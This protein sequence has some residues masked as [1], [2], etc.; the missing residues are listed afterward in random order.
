MPSTKRH[1]QIA[2][3]AE[4]MS[5]SIA[6]GPDTKYEEVTRYSRYQKFRDIVD[7]PPALYLNVSL[8]QARIKVFEQI[9]DHCQ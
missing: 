9:L 3:D 7:Y 4:N 6:F 8:I 1:F 2:F 5:D